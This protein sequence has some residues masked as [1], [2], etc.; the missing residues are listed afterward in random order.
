MSQ[1]T[2]EIP[3]F[4]FALRADLQGDRRFLPTKAHPTDTGFDVRAAQ[5]NR[6]PFVLQPFQKVMI[7]LGFRGFLPPGYWYKLV[8][9]SSTFWKR[10]LH[11]LYGTIDNS[12]EDQVCLVGTF[13]P[14]INLK[15][16]QY[17]VEGEVEF[18]EW[19][20]TFDKTLTI[21]FGDAIGQIIIEKLHEANV[22]EIDN[23][24]YD[25]LCA[26]RAGSR[27]T[28]S[29]GSSDSRGKHHD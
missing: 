27:G 20:H 29:F 5:A 16:S 4:K 19:S 23:D 21:N 10:D 11:C 22:Q 2:S 15:P 7:P 9:R 14:E 28:G 3:T 12:F 25:Q 1:Q 17:T 13:L 8:P 26:E 18:V 6:R 24:T